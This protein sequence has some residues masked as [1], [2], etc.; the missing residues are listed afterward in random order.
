MICKAYCIGESYNLDKV[1]NYFIENTERYS[2]G[3]LPKGTVLIFLFIVHA[4]ILIHQGL[5][6][7]MQAC[8]HARTCGTHAHTCMHVCTHE[9]IHTARFSFYLH[10]LAL[11]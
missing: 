11:Y 1:K 7:N 6:Q 10:L 3:L 2:L 5:A 8:M 9:H 4:Y